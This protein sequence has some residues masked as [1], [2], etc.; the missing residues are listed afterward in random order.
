MQRADVLRNTLRRIDGAGYKA[1]KDIEGAYDFDDFVLII[2]HVQGDPFAAPS[3]VRVRIPQRVAGFPEAAYRPKSREVALRD[4]ITR[5]FAR[6]AGRFQRPRA[7]GKSGVISIDRPGQEILERTS[8]FVNDREVELRFTVGLPAFGR[9]IAGRIAQEMFFEDIPALVR[10][11][12]LYR[13]IQG[14]SLVE[15]LK[16]NEDADALRAELSKAGIVAF[17]A[18]GAILPRESGVSQKPLSAGT[19][20]PFESPP[21]LRVEFTLPNRGKI[22]GMGIPHGVTLIVGG[23][24]H[25][26]STLLNALEMGVY[27]HIPGDGREFCVTIPEA[28]KI[29]AED[30]R[31]IEKVD[32][33]PFISH[34]PFGKDTTSFSTEDASGSTSQAANIIE[35]LEAGAKLLFIDEDTSATNFMIRDHRMQ[36][37]VSK[38]HEPITPFIDKVRLMLRDY[39]VSTVMVI[40]GSGDYFDVADRVVCLI[41][42]R[43]YEVTAKAKEIAQRY[44]TDRR[45][46]GGERFGMITPRVPLS[47]SFDP[48]KGKREVKISPKGLTSIHFGTH[49]IDLGA[50]EQLASVSQTRAI[51]DAIYY[52]TRYMDGRRPLAEILDRVMEDVAREGL[53]VLSP[54]PV[55]DYAAF[56]R[57]ELAAAID[58]LR[59]LKV[60]QLRESS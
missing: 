43:P 50:V 34:L 22:T 18:D 4:Y 30:G 33:S 35:A 60:R 12:G 8:C 3:R 47:E 16:T 48:S 20:V 27:N 44:R 17:V 32:I 5:I 29:R 49:E 19:V 53:D 15:H 6:E 26:K 55:G 11:A 1:Y 37:L 9:R 58:R 52:A 13:S 2:D 46:E 45:Q 23:G 42:Y 7:T 39:G 24:Y 56:R 57:F 25:G 14:R 10:R 28:V 21:S 31:R 54:F 36:E 51:G 40:G 38:D 59:T 41:E